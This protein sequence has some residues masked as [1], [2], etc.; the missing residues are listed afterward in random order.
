MHY[1]PICFSAFYKIP[2]DPYCSI[3]ISYTSFINFL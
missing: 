2:I 3:K 1:T